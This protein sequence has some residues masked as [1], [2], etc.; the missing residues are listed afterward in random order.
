[1]PLGAH[2]VGA[3]DVA[4]DVPTLDGTKTVAQLVDGDRVFGADGRSVTILEVSPVRVAPACFAIGFATGERIVVDEEQR[5]LIERRDLRRPTRVA[6]AEIADLLAVDGTASYAVRVAPP[7]QV[8]ARRLPIEP[9]LLGVWLALGVP[10]L[11]A[12][13]DA[14][15]PLLATL[16]RSGARVFTSEIAGRHW[17]ASGGNGPQGGLAGQL[18]DLHILDSKEIPMP[19]LRAGEDQRRALLAG[20]LDAAATVSDGGC[21]VLRAPSAAVA[22]GAQHLIASL[23]CRPSLRPVAGTAEVSFLSPVPVFRRADLQARSVARRRLGADP[24]PRRIVTGV[25]RVGPRPVRQLRIA[26]DDGVVLLGPTFVPM[27]CAVLVP[28]PRV[29]SPA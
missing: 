7:V 14:P 15:S 5:V 1:M 22:V 12:L 27:L 24:R 11:G 28:G 10:G 29:P 17:V 26:S 16:A 4:T 23:G 13:Q 3:L 8:C 2:H 18:R 19:Y 25:E 20:L 6:T 9:Y 21:I